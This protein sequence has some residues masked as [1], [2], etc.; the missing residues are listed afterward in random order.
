MNIISIKNH[1]T[2]PVGEYPD[3][4]PLNLL[5]ELYSGLSIY[6]A[7]AENIFQGSGIKLLNPPDGFYSLE[8]IF[9][10]RF[11]FI[12]TIE[13]IFPDPEEF[14]MLQSTSACGEWLPDVII[15]WTTNTKRPWIPTSRSR[16]GDFAPC[17][18]SW[19]RIVFFSKSC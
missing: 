14:F 13:H 10:L 1:F 11:F 5:E 7:I 2:Q 3:V 6:W 17:W 15:S 4:D 9:F 8:K 18:T 12:R 19:S 16:L